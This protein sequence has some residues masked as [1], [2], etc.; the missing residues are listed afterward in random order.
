MPKKDERT[1]LQEKLIRQIARTSIRYGVL[2]P[3]DRVLV[4][5][6]GGKD[7]SCLL[8][9]LNKLR[10]RLPF[11]LELTA[12]HVSQGQPGY[13]GSDLV[14]WLEHSGLPYKVVE[15]DTYAVV[16]RNTAEGETPCSVC[17]RMRRGILYTWAERLGCNK[18]ALGH[19]RE[20]TVATLLLN[21]FYGG[22]IQAMPARYTTNDG[23]F[24]VI[25]P[26]VETAGRDLAQ[27]ARLLE[28]PTVPCVLCANHQDHQRTAVSNL[29]DLLE[30]QNPR[31]RSSLLA[32]LKHVVPT[33]LLDRDLL[34]TVRAAED[35]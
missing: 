30:R 35:R 17:S 23:R 24:D 5:V 26:L 14:D 9:L 31:V 21:L 6:S 25:R 12:V 33:H 2:A 1:K 13:D 20:D 28:L 15:E 10:A 19:H 27:L 7:S 18:V 34:A 22:R 32:A 3:D 8:Y 29:L 4:A 11:S 16:A